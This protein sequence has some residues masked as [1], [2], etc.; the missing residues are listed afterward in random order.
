MMTRTVLAALIACSTACA[1]T[2]AAPPPEPAGWS[3]D[4]LSPEQSDV[5]LS[6]M[7][8]INRHLTRWVFVLDSA[9][10]NRIVPKPMA[11]LPDLTLAW[12]H[13]WLG[14]DLAIDVRE[15]VLADPVLLRGVLL[16]ELMHCGSGRNDH[17]PDSAGPAIMT[18]GP[19]AS[20]YA[21]ADLEYCGSACLPQ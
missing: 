3:L 18:S 14:H 8:E 12:S 4:L 11:E 5:A 15:D 1:V 9:A 10:P 16:H 21:P 19:G 13:G 7:A 20:E 6:A 2:P 17:L